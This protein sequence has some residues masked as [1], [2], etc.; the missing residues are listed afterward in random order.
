VSRSRRWSSACSNYIASIWSRCEA[1][2]SRFLLAAGTSTNPGTSEMNAPFGSRRRSHSDSRV[3]SQSP[4]P[5]IVQG[6]AVHISMPGPAGNRAPTRRSFNSL[7]GAKAIMVLDPTGPTASPCYKRVTA[8]LSSGWGC[9]PGTP[10]AGRVPPGRL[11]DAQHEPR[12]RRWRHRD[13]PR[14]WCWHSAPL[15][16]Q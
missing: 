14:Y 1:C 9:P 7:H 10:S 16:H 15:D 4:K 11:F 12:C 2:T 5:L 3:T 6:F 13:W 8:G